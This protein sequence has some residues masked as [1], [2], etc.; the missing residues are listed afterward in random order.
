MV[1]WVLKLNWRLSFY[2]WITV[3]KNVWYIDH[4]YTHKYKYKRLNAHIDHT[5]KVT[6]LC[7]SGGISPLIKWH[8]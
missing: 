2:H 7:P 5:V 4:M 8:H 3:T 6:Y 1:E